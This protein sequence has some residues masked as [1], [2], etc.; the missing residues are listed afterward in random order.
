MAATARSRAFDEEAEID[1]FWCVFDVEWPR[2][3]PGLKEAIEQA[4]QN[5][6]QL[7]VSNP[8]FELWL[9]LHFQEQGAWLDNANAR[10]L[11]GRLDGSRDKGLDAAKYMP[12]TGDAA[13]RAAELD[14]RHLQNDTLFP[15][16]NPSS[17]MHHLLAAVEQP[18]P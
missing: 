12:L 16:N 2:N 11:R 8:C 17:G 1:E 6:I 15:D 9:I 10:K 18:G 13:R 5:G 7:A 14:K 3:H 4:R